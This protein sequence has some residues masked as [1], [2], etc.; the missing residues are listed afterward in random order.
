MQ[1]KVL[2][3]DDN[4]DAA[5]SLAML[6]Q[7]EGHDVTVVHDG[8]E[9]ITAFESLH[10]DVALLDIGM[11]GVNGYD[12]ARHIRR[13]PHGRSIMLI[14]VT[15]WGQDSDKAQAAEAGFNH[16]FTKPMEPDVLSAL[17]ARNGDG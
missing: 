5:E 13:S 4:R 12:I 10:P 16:H 2:I 11:P 15:G 8:R 6:L 14:A 17:L 1:R 9:A 7:I 3:A